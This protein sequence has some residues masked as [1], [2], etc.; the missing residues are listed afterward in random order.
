[1]AALEGSCRT[2]IGAYALIE[3]DDLVLTVEALSPDG[4]HRFRGE[5]RVTASAGPVAAAALGLE[6]GRRIQSDGGALILLPD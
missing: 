2:A 3:G 1:M 6:L 5:G 4:V